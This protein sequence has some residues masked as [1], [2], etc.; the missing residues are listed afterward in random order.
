MTSFADPRGLWLCLI[1]PDALEALPTDHLGWLGVDLQHGRYEVSDLAGLLRVA[2]VPVLARAA[3]GDAAHLARVLDT[4]VAGVIVPGVS[5]LAEA[6]GLVGAVR[7]PPEGRRSTG[8]TRSVLVG[9]PGRPLL[10]AMV[11][12]AGALDD[13]G[14]IAAL[15][16]V[17]GLFV[18][19]YDLSLSLGRPGPTDAA[20][21]A[22]AARVRE[23]ARAHGVLAGA[24]SGDRALDALLPADLDLLAVDTDVTLL[25]V[26]MDAVLG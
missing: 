26:G 3:S 6:Q 24:F 10:L 13:V 2:R 19:P 8:L 20:V 9:G 14:A 21:V 18:G 12:T 4:G 17:D 15:D 23:A 25:R 11:E 7:F 1:G 22:A 5:S 16:G